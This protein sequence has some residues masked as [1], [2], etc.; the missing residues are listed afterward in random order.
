MFSHRSSYSLSFLRHS[1]IA[2]VLV[3]I[4]CAGLMAFSSPAIASPNDWDSAR[5]DQ[6]MGDPQEFARGTTQ[7]TTQYFEGYMQALIGVLAAASLIRL[8]FR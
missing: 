2:L 6:L 1:A 4:A 3:A 7:L 8:L 5:F